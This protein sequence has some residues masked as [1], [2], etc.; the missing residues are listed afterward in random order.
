MFSGKFIETVKSFIAK[1]ETC[2]FMSS[3]TGTP[4]YWKKSLF[5]V[6]GMVKQVELP[7]FFITLN[8]ADLQWDELIIEKLKG[9]KLKSERISSMD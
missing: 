1:D 2:N 8:N 7:T 5:Q 6:L 9:E 4:A 3:I